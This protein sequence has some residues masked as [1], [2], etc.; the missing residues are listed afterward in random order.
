MKTFASTLKNARISYEW[1]LREAA[2]NTNIDAA[3]LSKYENADRL[4]SE[5]HLTALAEGYKLQLNALRELWLAEK[6]T[7][8]LRYEEN[9]TNILHVAESRVEYLMSAKT[10]KVETLSETLQVQLKRIDVLVKKWKS[11]K[12]LN[13]TQLSK[14]RE[15]FS[16]EYIFESNRIE[17]NTL[18]L[19]ETHLVVNEGLTIGGKSMTEHLEAINHAD[20]IGFLYEL[21]G[22]KAQVTKRN[23]L[24]I[25]KLILKGIDRENA[26]KYR[27]IGVRISG[28]KHVPPEPYLV[29]SLMEDYFEHY[30]NQQRILHPIILAA[31]MHERLVSVHPFVDGNGRTSRLVMNLILLNAGY[32]VANLKGDLDSRIAYYK[33]LEKVQVDNDPD[34]FYRLVADAA[35]ESLT[36]HL[37]L[38]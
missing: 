24:D 1:K 21:A 10:F 16:T 20:A 34:A 30:K 13:A 5:K 23:L 29:Q 14:M 9:A 4:P 17:G 18:S 2:S 8:L 33:A 32:T 27:N 26:G 35:E 11:A 6:V 19:Q 36:E 15:Y 38:V 28:S 31:E 37:K 22:M 12:P 3:L 7:D 25:H